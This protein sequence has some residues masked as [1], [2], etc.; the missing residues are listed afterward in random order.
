MV[1]RNRLNEMAK[2]KYDWTVCDA[3]RLG[4]SISCKHQYSIFALAYQVP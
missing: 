3:T 4:A 2:S 1:Y